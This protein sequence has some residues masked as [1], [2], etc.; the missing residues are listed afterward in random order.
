LLR[1]LGRE[2]SAFQGKKLFEFVADKESASHAFE[3]VVNDGGDLEPVMD[4]TFVSQNGDL[5]AGKVNGNW[6]IHMLGPGWGDHHIMTDLPEEPADKLALALAENTHEVQPKKTDDPEGADT[7]TFATNP[8][9]TD[10][11]GAPAHDT[12]V[13]FI[14]TQVPPNPE[15]S[16]LD[17]DALPSD[18]TADE[19]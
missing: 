8:P 5:G 10:P 9:Y 1:Q 16:M 11:S 2:I 4:M 19:L 12:E 6:S 15:G 17:P 3:K 13:H 14:M 7:A 18:E